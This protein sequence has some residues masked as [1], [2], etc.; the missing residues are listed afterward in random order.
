MGERKKNAALTV[1]CIF[2]CECVAAVTQN[3]PKVKSKESLGGG[4]SENNT[5]SVYYKR[6]VNRFNKPF[7]EL[8]LCGDA[9]ISRLLTGDPMRGE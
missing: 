7:N 6:I 2:A 8:L 4:G 1:N 5:P 9:Y 3:L